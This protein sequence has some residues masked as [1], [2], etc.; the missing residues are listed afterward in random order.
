LLAAEG[1]YGEPA[2]RLGVRYDRDDV[3]RAIEVAGDADIAKRVTEI[4]AQFLIK[5]FGAVAFTVSRGTGVAEPP[6]AVTT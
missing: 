6:L 5:E 1:M 4:C 3:D 2:V